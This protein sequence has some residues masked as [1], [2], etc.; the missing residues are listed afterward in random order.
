MLYR[1]REA[2]TRFM[3]GRY[4][5]DSLNRFLLL[6]FFVLFIVNCFVKTPVI[7]FITLAILVVCYLRM[8]SKNI[9]K[10]QAENTAYL[11]LKNRVLGVFGCG[12]GGASRGGS[13][14][15]SVKDRMEYKYT[16]CPSCSQKL[17]VPR[18]QGQV[19]VRCPRCGTIFRE[20]T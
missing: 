9:P 6:I 17:R 20:R 16:A 11:R 18:G 3:Y 1:L 13:S 19:E 5:S 8:F 14:G 2:L 10:R 4:G 15:P 7:W 12:S